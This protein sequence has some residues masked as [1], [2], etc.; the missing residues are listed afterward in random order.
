MLERHWPWLVSVAA[1]AAAAACLLL[2]V[3]LAG[4]AAATATDVAAAS[5]PAL[6][7]R[8]GTAAADEYL[9]ESFYMRDRDHS[10]SLDAAEFVGDASDELRHMRTALFMAADHDGDGLLTASEFRE[11]LL[12]C[13]DRIR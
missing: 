3:V 7:Q 9:L 4:D 13:E 6:L 10:G 5:D 12:A 8:A 1:P 2:W 11:Q